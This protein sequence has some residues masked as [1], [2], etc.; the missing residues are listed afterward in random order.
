MRTPLALTLATLLAAPAVGFAQEGRATLERAAAALGA[1]SLRSIQVTASVYLPK[2]KLLS[3]ADAFTPSPANAP[4]PTPPSPA[5]VH[6]ADT[7]ARLRLSVDQLLPLHGRLVPL[8]ELHRTIGR[9]N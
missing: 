5:T 2:E 4:V 1:S 8:A 9:A 3:Q 7:I 6:L